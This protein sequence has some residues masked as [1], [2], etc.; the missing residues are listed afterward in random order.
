MT[1]LM[2]LLTLAV[3]AGVIAVATGVIRGGLDEPAQTVPARALPAEGVTGRDVASLR[4]V[5]GFRGYRMDQVDAALDTLAIEV[6]RL[7]AQVAQEKSARLQLA[8]SASGGAVTTT[9]EGIVPVEMSQTPRDQAARPATGGPGTG[10]F[11]APG[12]ATPGTGS[13]PTTGSQPSG[14]QPS[15]GPGTGSFPA[16]GPSTGSVPASESIPGVSGPGSFPAADAPAG[17]NDPPAGPVTGPL[18]RPRRRA[19]GGPST[20]EFRSRPEGLS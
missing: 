17:Q 16:S 5:Q 9:G 10:S 7:R 3:V 15:S 13:L 12:A 1:L 6:D 8:R 4:F 19:A 14:G 2:V 20:G 11:E 18:R